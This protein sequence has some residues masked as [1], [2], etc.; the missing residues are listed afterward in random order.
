M[1]DIDISV[2]L[3][4]KQMYVFYDTLPIMINMFVEFRVHF[5]VGIKTAWRYRWRRIVEHFHCNNRWFYNFTMWSVFILIVNTIIYLGFYNIVDNVYSALIRS[6]I[7]FQIKTD[8]KITFI[9]FYNLLFCIR[10][11]SSIYFKFI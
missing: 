11:K 7:I 3:C 1:V 9:I 8:I 5:R 4:K 2:L 10:C 6:M